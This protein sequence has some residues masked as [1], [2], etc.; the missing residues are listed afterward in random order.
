MYQR[1]LSYLELSNQNFLKL[2]LETSVMIGE[3]YPDRAHLFVKTS[4]HPNWNPWKSVIGKLS[5]KEEAA[6]KIRVFAMVDF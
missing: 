1:I 3:L 4:C 2:C 6:G 5:L